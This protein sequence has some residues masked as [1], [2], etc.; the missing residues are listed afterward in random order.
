MVAV[1]VILRGVDMSFVVFFSGAIIGAAFSLML[2]VSYFMPIIEKLRV[3]VAKLSVE[4]LH[5]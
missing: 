4:L 2:C 3:K 1:S 5:K